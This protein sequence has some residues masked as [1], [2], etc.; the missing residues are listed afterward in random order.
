MFFLLHLCLSHEGAFL[1]LKYVYKVV[2]PFNNLLYIQ[3]LIICE[4]I[5]TNEM[6]L[7]LTSTYF[8]SYSAFH[9]YQEGHSV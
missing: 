2:K 5:I 3:I 9:A 7:F 4:S 6:E 8:I 1:F